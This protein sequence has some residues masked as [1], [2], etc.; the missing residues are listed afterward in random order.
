[1]TVTLG[2]SADLSRA[3]T[4]SCKLVA[5]NDFLP[6]FSK[7]AKISPSRTLEENVDCSQLS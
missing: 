5:V 4:I 2:T 1:L 6:R 3:R 7:E